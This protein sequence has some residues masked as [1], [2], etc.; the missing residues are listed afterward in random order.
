MAGERNDPMRGRNLAATMYPGLRSDSTERAL[1]PG[2]WTMSATRR[3]GIQAV[4][5][6][7]VVFENGAFKPTKGK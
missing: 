4:F 2:R 6:G 7:D 1:P 3:A 5:R